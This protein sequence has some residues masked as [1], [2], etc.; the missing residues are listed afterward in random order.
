MC[1][2]NP[3][4]V[5]PRSARCRRYQKSVSEQKADYIAQQ[6]QLTPQLLF[7]VTYE[8]SSVRIM[9]THKEYSGGK[10]R[11]K[12]SWSKNRNMEAHLCM[13]RVAVVTSAATAKS[14][15]VAIYF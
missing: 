5:G 13:G 9:E 7:E 11:T 14:D 10:N 12:T 1:P 4:S 3:L 8:I 2:W 15:T 6:L